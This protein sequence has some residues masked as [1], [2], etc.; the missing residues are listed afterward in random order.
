MHQKAVVIV[1]QGYSEE[2]DMERAVKQGCRLSPLLFTVNAET[3]MKEARNKIE[4]GIKVGGKLVRDVRFYDDQGKVCWHR[5]GLQNIMDS[6]N[7]TAERYGMK[8]NIRKL[9]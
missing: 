4:E 2:S 9:N 1:T 6:L 3:M 7:A 8:I 5:G